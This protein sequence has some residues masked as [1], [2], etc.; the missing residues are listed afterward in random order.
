M[1][2]LQL[3]GLSK[4]ECHLH[5]G[6]PWHLPLHC[7]RPPGQRW[8]ATTSSDVCQGSLENFYLHL[9]RFL[10]GSSAC[11]VNFQAFLLDDITRWNSCHSTAA[12]DALPQ[13]SRT[14]DFHLQEKLNSLSLHGQEM[15]PCIDLHLSIRG[16]YLGQIIC[17]GSQALS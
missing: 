8:S 15:F 9:T 7:C 5:P 10:P 14:F 1:R 3:F 13:T 11:A 6:S 17:S 4:Q 2:R 12:I 16:N